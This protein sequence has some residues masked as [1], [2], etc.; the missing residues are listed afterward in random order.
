MWKCTSLH[1]FW[2]FPRTYK[3]NTDDI[4]ENER[5]LLINTVELI[6]KTKHPSVAKKMFGSKEAKAREFLESLFL[7]LS[8][9]FDWSKNL[10][11]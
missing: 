11:D 8:K 6:I 4:N 10:V 5:E 7:E 9:E 3:G 2:S 1:T